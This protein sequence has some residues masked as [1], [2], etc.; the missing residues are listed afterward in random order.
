M[1]TDIAEGVILL[2]ILFGIPLIITVIYVF[3]QKLIMKLPHKIW[4]FVPLIF[5]CVLTV[6]GY[7]RSSCFIVYYSD[8]NNDWT[9][10]EIEL[11]TCIHGFLT[12]LITMIVVYLHQ[13]NKPASPAGKVRKG[14]AVAV[15]VFLLA[16]AAVNIY[17]M[18]SYDY[19]QNTV[20]FRSQKLTT[21]GEY[22]FDRLHDGDFDT[23]IHLNKRELL[24]QIDNNPDA[25]N[26][27]RY[28]DFE[29]IEFLDE[30]TVMIT[31][32]V[33]FQSVRGYLITDGQKSYP[34]GF[35]ELPGS[36]YDGSGIYVDGGSDNIY[37]WSAG[38]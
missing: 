2:G 26:A 29:D 27:V 16:S 36:G 31:E 3:L 4:H 1:I 20:N 11:V 22:M 38:L 18:A 14:F 33:I 8:Y 17:E 6:Y 15:S 25:Y 10:G 9:N 19:S 23:D 5:F 34:N 13:R 12:S 30:H 32:E 28:S 35:L 21:I 24:E 7:L 37:S